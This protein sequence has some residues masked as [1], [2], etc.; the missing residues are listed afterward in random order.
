MS[1]AGIEIAGRRGIAPAFFADD[2]GYRI[3][4]RHWRGPKCALTLVL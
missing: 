4:H 1:T 2:A 3:V